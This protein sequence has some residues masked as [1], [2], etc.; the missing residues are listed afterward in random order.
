MDIRRKVFYPVAFSAMLFAS[1]AMA[2]INSTAFVGVTQYFFKDKAKSIDMGH[3]DPTLGEVALETGLIENI[4]FY[5]PYEAAF[6]A[7][8]ERDYT[9]DKSTDPLWNVAKILFP[10]NNGQLGT[11]TGAITNFARYVKNPKTV[12]L[13]EN[14]AKQVEDVRGRGS[15]PGKITQ[16]FAAE[17]LKTLEGMGAGTEGLKN[18]KQKTLN[19]LLKAIQESIEAEKKGTSFYPRGTTAHYPSLF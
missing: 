12:A 14:Y 4:V 15:L 11:T 16:H 6:K 19:P 10:S 1:S 5:G 3:Y 17:I 18:F 2:K 13:L 9:K 8:G 7:K